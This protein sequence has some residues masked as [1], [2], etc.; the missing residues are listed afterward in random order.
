MK[1]QIY[2]TVKILKIWTPKKFAVITLKVEQAGI[3]NSV[4]PDQTA[5]KDADGIANSVGPDQT[6]LLL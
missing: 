2:Y 6:A 1:V 3:L 4:D 5:S